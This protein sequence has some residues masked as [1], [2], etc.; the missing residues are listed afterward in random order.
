[1]Q[2]RLKTFALLLAV[3][4]SVGCGSSLFIRRTVYIDDHSDQVI[5]L[6]EDIEDVKVW[7]LVDGE[8]EP[9]VI[10]RLPEGWYAM[11]LSEDDKTTTPP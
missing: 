1:M 6:R 8:W 10:D 11:A 5:R 4:F 7:V 9:T 2:N 3:S